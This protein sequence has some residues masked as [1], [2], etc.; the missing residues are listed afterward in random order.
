M[1]EYKIPYV[2][3]Y[4]PKLF[5]K[6]AEVIQ[7]HMYVVLEKVR[8]CIGIIRGLNLAPVKPTTV[9]VINCRFRLVE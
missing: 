8:P 9:H 6:Q 5:R 1:I 4:I 2:Y 7:K 3:D